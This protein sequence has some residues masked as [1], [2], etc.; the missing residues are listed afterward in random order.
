MARLDKAGE[1]G[2]GVARCGHVWLVWD[3]Q[4]WHCRAWRVGVWYGKFWQARSGA[5]YK[6]EASCGMVWQ[7]W[8]GAR[9]LV[10]VGL[11]GRGVVWQAKN[12]RSFENGLFME[13]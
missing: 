1:V 4:A 8:S 11:I 6:G 10:L 7:A 12:E 5:V 9:W 13:L 3:W 2:K